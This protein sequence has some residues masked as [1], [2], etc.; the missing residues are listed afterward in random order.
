M[1]SKKKFH[2]YTRGEKNCFTHRHIFLKDYSLQEMRRKCPCMDCKGNRRLTCQRKTRPA[3][4]EC[5]QLQWQKPHHLQ[6]RWSFPAPTLGQLLH[7]WHLDPFAQEI[8]NLMFIHSTT[9][10]H[11]R[12]HI[13]T[14]KTRKRKT[15]LSSFKKHHHRFYLE[16]CK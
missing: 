4:G 8:Q 7:A 15:R 14:S 1:S 11:R 10:N 3:S 5:D 6:V 12:P 2:L 13:A 9:Q 16:L